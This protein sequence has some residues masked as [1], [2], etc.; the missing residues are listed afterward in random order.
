MV[1]LLIGVL[2][3]AGCAPAQQTP[4]TA[5]TLS[6][7]IKAQYQRTRDV[8]LRSADKVPDS[9][10]GF[11]PTEEVR[12][13]GQLVAH[14]AD[15]QYLFCSAAM[16]ETSPATGS[17]EKTKTSKPELVAAL[18]AAFAKGCVRLLRSSIQRHDRHSRGSGGPI[19]WRNAETRGAG[20][21]QR[22]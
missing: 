9:D 3:V 6:G 15:E 12:S 8:I 7:A 22:P 16:E 11:E 21:Q 19:L 20:V 5:T 1:R 14:L 10:Y 4:L 13:F 18:K 2:A 17:V